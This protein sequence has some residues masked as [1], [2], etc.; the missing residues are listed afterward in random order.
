[1]EVLFYYF[2]YHKCSYYCCMYT[3]VQ[4]RRLSIVFS[5]S[6]LRSFQP[7]LTFNFN[8][9]AAIR[10]L[11]VDYPKLNLFILRELVWKCS[12][13]LIQSVDNK[14]V[15]VMSEHCWCFPF[16]FFNSVSICCALF[17]E[18]IYYIFCVK[19]YI[20]YIYSKRK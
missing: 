17:S 16:T 7:V 9:S 5:L 1:M 10:I 11:S 19:L 18:E 8:L 2:L 12:A 6:M 14:K 13:Y 15:E 20:Q 4:N 3:S